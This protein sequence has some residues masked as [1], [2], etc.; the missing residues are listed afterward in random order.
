MQKRTAFFDLGNVVVFFQIPKMLRNVSEVTGVPPS[1]VYDHWMH[2]GPAYESGH[3]STEELYQA[4]KKFAVRSFSLQEFMGAVSSLFSPNKELEP[5]LFSLKSQGIRLIALSNTNECHFN[6]LYSNYPVLRLFD[7][8]VL[9]HRVGAAKPDPRIFHYALS[10]VS[11]SP[12]ECFYTDDV[13]EFISAAKKLGM[14]AELFKDVP[15]L[16]AQLG[17]RGLLPV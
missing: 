4:A 16:K 5:V 8:Y 14:D 2:L 9:S 13:P 12:K 6:W 10:K 11:E 7:D 3:L 15:L 1:T 17:K